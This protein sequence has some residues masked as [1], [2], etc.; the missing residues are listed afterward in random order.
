M[1][2]SLMEETPCKWDSNWLLK[3]KPLHVNPQIFVRGGAELSFLFFKVENLNHQDT[4]KMKQE[5]LLASPCVINLSRNLPRAYL[6]TKWCLRWGWCDPFDCATSSFWL[7]D[8][9]RWS[10]YFLHRNTDLIPTLVVNMLLGFHTVYVLF[11]FILFVM[12]H[13][14]S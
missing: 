7:L 3:D 9:E 2:V 4:S 11:N 10:L 13:L 14:T 12:L 5:Q 1:K 8:S 6:Q